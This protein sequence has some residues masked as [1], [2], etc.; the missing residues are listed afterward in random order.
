[1]QQKVSE[2]KKKTTHTRALIYCTLK[3]FFMHFVS[4]LVSIFFAKSLFMKS[5]QKAVISHK[6]KNLNK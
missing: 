6:N 3:I 4:V 5:N 1:M 2:L